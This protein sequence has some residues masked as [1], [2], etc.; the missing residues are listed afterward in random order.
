MSYAAGKYAL[1]LCDRCGFQYKLNE[2]KEEW[3]KLKTCPECFEPKAPQLESPPV[4]RDPEALYNPRPNNDKESG[5]GFVVVVDA[6][7][8][9]DTSN[10]FLAMNPATLGTNFKLDKM[11]TS[12]GTVT[13]TT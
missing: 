6:N 11:T 1:G 9:S 4:V 7:V 13:I 10:N 8:F 12:I 3:N 2:L 5:E